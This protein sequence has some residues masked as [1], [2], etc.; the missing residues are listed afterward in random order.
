MKKNLRMLLTVLLM[1]TGAIL[2]AQSHTVKGKV[3]DDKMG[4][5]PGVSIVVKGT[6]KGT[7]TDI[8]GKVKNSIGGKGLRSF[9]GLT[10]A[11]NPIY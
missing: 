4:P 8:D 5:I 7:I 10:N 3:T 9:S 2:Y 1:T 6:T 11:R